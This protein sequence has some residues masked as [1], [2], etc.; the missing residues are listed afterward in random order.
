MPTPRGGPRWSSP[1]VRGILRNPTY[2][3]QVH[4]QRTQYRPPTYRA[5]RRTPSAAPM[6]RPCPSR[7]KPGSSW[8][9]CPPW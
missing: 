5:R 4:A 1:T 2:T 3:G 6:A 9:R 8:A 7:P